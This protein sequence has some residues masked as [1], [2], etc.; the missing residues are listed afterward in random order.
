[1]S[2]KSGRHDLVNL[3]SIG[4]IWIEL[5]GHISDVRQQTIFHENLRVHTKNL[6]K[7]QL[8]IYLINWN[9]NMDS[10]Y[11]AINLSEKRG[12][13]ILWRI[14]QIGIILDNT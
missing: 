7:C 12:W 3:K 2:I 11:T 5:D 1:M 6:C 4:M 14:I 9:T 10:K 13:E 8:V